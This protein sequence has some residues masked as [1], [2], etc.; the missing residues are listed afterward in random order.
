[1]SAALQL[2]PDCLQQFMSGNLSIEALAAMRPV[3]P[4]NEGKVTFTVACR[5]T[6][7]VSGYM[8]LFF[9]SWRSLPPSLTL[10]QKSY[11]R[12]NSPKIA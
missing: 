4:T 6:M 1:M 5:K 3:N 9:L 10:P 11:F 12:H 8:P 2:R 7:C